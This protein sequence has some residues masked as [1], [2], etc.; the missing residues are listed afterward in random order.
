LRGL[1]RILRVGAAGAAV[2]HV[3]SAV[4]M[5]RRSSLADGRTYSRQHLPGLAALSYGLLT[6]GLAAVCAG[7][8]LSLAV[9]IAVG[10][11]LLAAAGIAAAASLSA[12]PLRMLAR[13]RL[14][15][16]RVAGGAG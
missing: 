4:A 10:G 7:F 6:A 9:L 16:G 11:G 12:R 5:A 1:I 8:A 2:V 14:G 13:S 3:A 15:Q